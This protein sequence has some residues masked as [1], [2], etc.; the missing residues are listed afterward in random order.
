M[1]PLR[2]MISSR[3][4]DAVPLNGEYPSLTELRNEIKEDLEN[5]QLFKQALFAVWI[6][7]E[8]YP[9]PGDENAWEHCL[10]QAEESEI[11]ICLF[12][13]NAGWTGPQRGDFGI[14]HAELET[15]LKTGRAKVRLVE[16]PEEPDRKVTPADK[17]FREFIDK[18]GLFRGGAIATKE[19]LFKRVHEAVLDAVL[20]LARRGRTQ[21][22]KDRYDRGEALEWNRLSFADRKSAI[23]ETI[24]DALKHR[25]GSEENND[26]QFVR[27]N[28]TKVLVRVS[29]VPGPMNVAEARELMGRPHLS[30]YTATNAL[31]TANRAG[32]IHIIGCHRSV[33]ETQ[34]ISVLGFPDA[35]TV[36]SGFGVYVADN[37]Q[38]VQLIFL[39]NCRDNAAT[40]HMVQLLF[41]WLDHSGEA[42]ELV[43]RAKSRRR[44]VRAIAKEQT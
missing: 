42:A 10:R 14:C 21:S 11:F 40:R 28:S 27:I 43:Q 12:N 41:D 34:A 36:K 23:E 18:Q 33:T 25:Q 26:E 15:A 17:R 22:K 2:V 24:I 16:L 8:G 13:G 3:C 19:D 39:A 7:E 5:E 35:V 4:E 6:N 32:P 31:T 20:D 1:R 30:D 38:K 44:I 9:A 29:A 37:V